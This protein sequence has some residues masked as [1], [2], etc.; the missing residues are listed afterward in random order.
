MTPGRR[1]RTSGRR[2]NTRQNTPR[3]SVQRRGTRTSSRAAGG[4]FSPPPYAIPPVRSDSSGRAHA[5]RPTPWREPAN[6]G[7]GHRRTTAS[8][9]RVHASGF[10]CSQLIGSLV[11]ELDIAGHTDPPAISESLSQLAH[12]RT[13]GCSYGALRQCLYAMPAAS[14]TSRMP[15]QWRGH[16][17]GSGR[18]VQHCSSRALVVLATS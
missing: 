10:Q 15:L 12:R 7:H 11:R 17:D 8:P 2:P 6:R 13:P 5:H 14:C 4:V 3:S 1:R 9:N 18:P 16:A